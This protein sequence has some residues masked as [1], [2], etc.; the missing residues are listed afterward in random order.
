MELKRADSEAVAEMRAEKLRSFHVPLLPNFHV[1]LAHHADVFGVW[2]GASMVG[3]AMLLFDK[4]EGHDHVTLVEGYLTPPYRDRY[5]DM[6]DVL[7]EELAPRAYLARSDDCTFETA[8]IAQGFAMEVSMMVMVARAAVSPEPREELD[9]VPLDYPHLRAAHDLMLHA[10]GV[11]QAPTYSELEQEMENDSHWVLLDR[12]QAVGLVI[13]ERSEGTRYCLLDVLAP[14]VGDDVLVWGLHTAGRLIAGNEM[15]PAAL[16]DARDARR[17]QVFRR[18][19]YYTAAGY[20]VFYD[21]LAGRPSVPV[22]SRD[23]L[24]ELMQSG[25][26]LHVVD[27]L[28]EDHWARGHLPGAE[29]IDF[30]SLTREARKRYRKD[31]KIVVYCNDFT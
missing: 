21:Q 14:H 27:V 2:D 4:H 24:W 6:L 28:G 17:L 3:Y 25:T 19:G 11:Q 1:H 31:E 8:L 9:L 26:P 30:R 22:I 5:E 12:E 18:A 15:T 7:R 29:W 13:R 23:E 10:R 20:L 16:V